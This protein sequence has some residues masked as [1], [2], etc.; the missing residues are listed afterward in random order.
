MSGMVGLR[1]IPDLS[2]TDTDHVEIWTATI[3]WGSARQLLN[4]GP[5]CAEI[6]NCQITK[7]LT[8]SLIWHN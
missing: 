4:L 7:L 8:Q 6:A 5:K 3:N 1:E 2:A